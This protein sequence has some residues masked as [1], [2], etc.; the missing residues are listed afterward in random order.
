[1]NIKMK[2][3]ILAAG[4]S[5]RMYPVTLDKPKCLLELEPGKTIIDHQVDMLNKCGIKDIIVLVGY[6][7]EKIEEVLKNRAKYRHFKDFAKYNNLH[8]L[9]SIKDELNDDLVVL[10]SDGIFG[11]KLL[12][13]CLQSKEDFC[14]L[15]HNKTVLKDTAKV[16]IKG[17]IIAEIGNHIT[18]EEADGNFIGIAKFSKKGAKILVDEMSRMVKDQK[19]NNSYYITAMNEIAKKAGIQCQ[20][21]T[22]VYG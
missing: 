8:T 4:R 5:T 1:M 13:K 3:V 7:K 18:S 15:V 12:E 21:K 22:R 2:S 11:K 20:M 19:H 10:Y 9:Y 14:L 17:K 16:K 6:L